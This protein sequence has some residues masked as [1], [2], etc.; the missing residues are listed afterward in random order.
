VAGV[1]ECDAGNPWSPAEARVSELTYSTATLGN[2][3]VRPP[4]SGVSRLS[5]ECKGLLRPFVSLTSSYEVDGYIPGG[6]NLTGSLI[7]VAITA[8]L[9]SLTFFALL[10]GL[11]SS[12]AGLCAIFL[13]VSPSRHP[14]LD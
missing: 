3:S 7:L 2:V 1:C 13:T 9:G 6:D 8:A 14:S 12:G 4:A 5:G 10:G 11:R